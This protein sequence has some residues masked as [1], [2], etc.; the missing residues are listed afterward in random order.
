MINYF[1]FKVKNN[2]LELYKMQLVK[3]K[4]I[5]YKESKFDSLD[6][7]SRAMY[8]GGFGTGKME[9]EQSG[10]TAGHQPSDAL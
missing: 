1:F 7:T 3:F 4:I 5:G 10:G 8:L 9:Q 2:S 6:S